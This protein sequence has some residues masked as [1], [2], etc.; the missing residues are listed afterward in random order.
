M[1]ENNPNFP[2]LFKSITADNGSEFASLT[3][4]VQGISDV[5]FTHPYSSWER[6]TNENHNGIIRRFIAKG[7]SMKEISHTTIKQIASWMNHLPRKK[8]NYQTP[9]E[10]FLNYFEQMQTVENPILC[11]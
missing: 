3:A 7:Q 2:L 9:L 6:G 4:A 11:H 1:S 10:V 5:Y 8:L